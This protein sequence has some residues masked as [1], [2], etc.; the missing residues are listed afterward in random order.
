MQLYGV[1]VALA[2]AMEIH[3][4]VEEEAGAVMSTNMYL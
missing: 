4:V 1:A 3:I 2:K